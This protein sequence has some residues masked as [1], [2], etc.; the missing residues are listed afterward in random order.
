MK[1]C[2]L[3]DVMVMQPR[4]I[5]VIATQRDLGIFSF[6]N[7]R[8]IRAVVTISKFSISDADIADADVSPT[9]NKTEAR[10]SLAVTRARFL[11]SD[12][13]MCLSGLNIF[14]FLRQVNAIITAATP[15]PMF[16][17]ATVDIGPMSDTRSDE[18]GVEVEA[19]K[20]A[21]NAQRIATAYL[22]LNLFAIMLSYYVVYFNYMLLYLINDIYNN[23]C[24]CTYRR[25]GLRTF[26]TMGIN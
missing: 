25:P 13:L 22:F 18:K 15:T 11:R 24:D 12:F 10:K 23:S 17:N 3:P 20:A 16:M 19:I 4:V 14:L 1:D 26:S 7:T 6:R 9:I 21:A 8:A 2:R 5:R